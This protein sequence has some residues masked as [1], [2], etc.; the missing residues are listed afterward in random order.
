[1]E[2]EKR[3]SA[4]VLQVLD[5][6]SQQERFRY[7]VEPQDE[8]FISAGSYNIRIWQDDNSDGLWTSNEAVFRSE[9]KVR[10]YNDAVYLLAET[11]D[12]A[13]AY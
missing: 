5:S 3:E 1:M 11:L 8:L 2:K 7:L 4:L 6:G 10:L 12:F 9:A 13:P